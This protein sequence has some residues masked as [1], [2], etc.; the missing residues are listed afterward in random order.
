MAP[1]INQIEVVKDALKIMTIF[2]SATVK[3]ANFRDNKR[4]MYHFVA[5]RE[6]PI[7]NLVF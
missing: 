3:Q 4:S 2:H 5:K 6:G 1:K 7:Y